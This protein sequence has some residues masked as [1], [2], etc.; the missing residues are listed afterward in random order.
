MKETTLKRLLSMTLCAVL[1]V[2]V[3]GCQSSN[4]NQSSNGAGNGSSEEKTELIIAL[5]SDVTTLDICEGMGSATSTACLNI[6]DTLTR[7]SGDGTVQPWLAE[8]FEAVSGTTWQFKLRQNVTFTNGEPFNAETVKYSFERQVNPEY[9]FSLAGDYD[10]IESVEIVD[11]YTVN[12]NTKEPFPMLPLWLTYLGMLPPAYTE[13]AGPEGFAV[14]PVGTGPY[15]FKEWVKDSHLTL[16]ANENYFMGAPAFQTLT[17]KIIPEDS[18]RIL[19]LQAGEVDIAVLVPPSQ[20]DQINA[21]KGVS[22]VSGPTSRP[23]YLGMNTIPEGPLQDVRVRQAIC[24]ALDVPAIID[25]VLL[26]YGNQI[27]ALSLPCWAGHDASVKPYERDL[28][29]AKQLLEQ[30]G[31][32][33]GEGLSFNLDVV[34]GEYPAIKE[35]AQAV[36]GQLTEAGISTSVVTMDK[37]TFRSSLKDKSADP[38]YITGFGG[39]TSCNPNIVSLILSAG[40]RYCCYEDP[41]ITEL[42]AKG[43]TEMDEA[44][45]NRI[46]S[47]IQNSIKEDAPVSSLYQLY[48]IYGVSDQISWTPRLDEAIIASEITPAR[49]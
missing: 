35:V 36:A 38:L 29:K 25:N 42:I 45:F 49:S 12:F 32:P 9:A 40:Q 6:F 33:N 19:A 4:P 23:I 17:F 7:G 20:I 39:M 43:T 15:I 37:T 44:A 13:E 22:I 30:A 27:A 46:W 28:D 10:N 47:E 34:D 24:Y 48:G 3:S 21:A 5:N 8:S 11:E 41:E 16:T 14:N 2:G 26:G 31:Y 1:V 18:T